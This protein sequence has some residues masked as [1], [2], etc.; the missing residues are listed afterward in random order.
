MK[1]SARKLFAWRVD[2]FLVSH[3]DQQLRRIVNNVIGRDVERFKFEIEATSNFLYYTMSYILNYSTPGM[4]VF[5]LSTECRK[6]NPLLLCA[7]FISNWA[8]HRFQNF[9]MIEGGLISPDL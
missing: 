4:M 1:G 3:F 8:F 9:I 7:Y 5:N 2:N 6:P